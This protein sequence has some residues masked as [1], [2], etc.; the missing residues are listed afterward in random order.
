MLKTVDLMTRIN[1]TELLE[2]SRLAR[3]SQPLQSIE[4][5]RL[6]RPMYPTSLVKRIRLTDLIRS[7]RLNKVAA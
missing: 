6:I 1:I 5:V 4:L 3:L 7:R 2:W